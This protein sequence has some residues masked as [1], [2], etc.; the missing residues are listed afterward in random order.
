MVLHYFLYHCSPMLSPHHI[1]INCTVHGHGKGLLSR[2]TL[3]GI[4]LFV[5]FLGGTGRDGNP[6]GVVWR[7]GVHMT[8]SVEHN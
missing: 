3:Y 8:C 2:V 4:I 7:G 6:M 5:L 1:Y